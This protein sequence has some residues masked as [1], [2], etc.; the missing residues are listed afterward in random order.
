MIN[1]W[2]SSHNGYVL[3]RLPISP[4]RFSRGRAAP[5]PNS[6]RNRLVS[7]SVWKCFGH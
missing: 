4:M 7:A 1:P 5:D 2:I 3:T 6:V